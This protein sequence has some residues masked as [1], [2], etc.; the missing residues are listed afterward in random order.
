LQKKQTSVINTVHGQWKNFFAVSLTPMNS[1]SLLSLTPLNNLSSVSMFYQELATLLMRLCSFQSPRAS[2]SLPSFPVPLLPFFPADLAY[3]N[4][5][6]IFI[7]N[8]FEDPV[9]EK[10]LLNGKEKIS[11]KLEK[12]TALW[13][14]G[15]I[16]F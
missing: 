6:T 4:N 1:L 16:L 9:I 2:M 10:H 8:S 14:K 7:K 13:N 12:T 5:I 15:K 3:L 11:D